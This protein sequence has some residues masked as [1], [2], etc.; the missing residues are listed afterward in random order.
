[1][2]ASSTDQ[3]RRA[4]EALDE[5]AQYRF[6]RGEGMLENG[7]RTSARCLNDR[8]RELQEIATD[9]RASAPEAREL[10]GGRS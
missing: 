5:E 1:M 3:I 2:E 8:A 10:V 6:E 7:A 4:A 9:L